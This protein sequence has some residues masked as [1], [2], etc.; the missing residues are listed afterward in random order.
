MRKITSNTLFVAVSPLQ[1]MVF[2]ATFDIDILIR[3]ESLQEAFDLAAKIGFD[4]HE[5][6]TSFKERLWK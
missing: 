2:H 4:T 1:F 3:D 5:F 6:D